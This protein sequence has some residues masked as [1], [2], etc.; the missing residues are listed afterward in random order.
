MSAR[1]DSLIN[2][3]KR[4]RITIPLSHKHHIFMSISHIDL[5]RTGGIS[6]ALV[7]LSNS[8]ALFSSAHHLFCNSL[9]KNITIELALNGKHFQ[10]AAHIVQED[11]IN[12]LYGIKFEE[13]LQ[14]ID[15]YLFEF[16]IHPHHEY[17]QKINSIWLHFS[18]A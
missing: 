8:G 10:F 4:L 17:A 2:N 16:H 3:E 11:V 6:V 14:I 9:G 7:S 18:E 5:F 12:D 1:L 15:D 13:S